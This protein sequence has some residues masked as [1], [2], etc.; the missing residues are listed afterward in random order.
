MNKPNTVIIVVNWRLKHQTMRCL[1]S[2]AHVE[3]PHRIVVVDNGS[4]DGSAEFLKKHYP[5]ITLL[6]LPDNIGFGAA[7]NRAIQSLLPDPN[8]EY[9]FMVNNDAV[10]HPESLNYLLRAAQNNPEAGIFGPKIYYDSMPRQLW[11]AGARRRWGVLAAADTG[12]DQLDRGQ[13]DERK[14]IDFVFGAGMFLRRSVIETI[15]L[16]DEQF[17]IYLEDL[18][19]CLR[20][21]EAGFSLQFVPEALLWHRVSASTETNP[22]WRRYH[23]ARSTILF[24]IK[25]TTPP[26]ALP[27]LFFW[28][29]V[30]LRS[31][32]KDTLQGNLNS[33]KSYLHG[34]L[35]GLRLKRANHWGEDRNIK[36]FSNPS[37][38]DG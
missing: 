11:F 12:R 24:L 36:P 15:G 22:G 31:V 9:L 17:F 37:L 21:Q 23:Q 19:L 8:W 5:G 16:F 7:C 28:M 1:N 14:L 2:L 18:D 4:Q 3:S 30:F 26:L 6:T 29:A 35:D 38:S 32:L 20:A 10:L 33:I 27:V 13:Y 34:L 25:H